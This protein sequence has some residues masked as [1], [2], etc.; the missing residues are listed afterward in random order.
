MRTFIIC[1][2]YQA[3][4]MVMKNKKL[5]AVYIKSQN[6][7]KLNCSATNLG[8]IHTVKKSHWR[9][10]WRRW[11]PSCSGFLGCCRQPSH[12]LAT[13]H[14]TD[15]TAQAYVWMDSSTGYLPVM[16]RKKMLVIIV[17]LASPYK[18]LKLGASKQKDGSHRNRKGKEI[19][20]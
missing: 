20:V 18:W 17:H 13:G 16:I 3:A 4:S 8:G 7:M 10:S 5:Q 12:G 2:F 9:I 14:S 11:E 6:I 1:F 19:W 15:T